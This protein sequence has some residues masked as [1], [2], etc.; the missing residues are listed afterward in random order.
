MVRK[1]LKIRV[2]DQCIG[3]GL[4]ALVIV[5]LIGALYVIETF[6]LING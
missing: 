6:L 2:L 4:V 3:L 1:P 5:L